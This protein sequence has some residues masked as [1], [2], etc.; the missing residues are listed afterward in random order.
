MAKTILVLIFEFG[1]LVFIWYLACLREAAPAEA[2]AWNLVLPY[3]YT[4]FAM[5][6]A[7]FLKCLFCCHIPSADLD[8]F[9]RF[10]NDALMMG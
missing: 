9:S 4:F 10:F 1:T 7:L 2:G 6:E 5:P 8:S 3:S